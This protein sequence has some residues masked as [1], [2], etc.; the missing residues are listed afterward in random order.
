MAPNKEHEYYLILHKKVCEDEIEMERV[1]DD[2][3][4][5]YAEIVLLVQ[6][7]QKVGLH[8]LD[9]KPEVCA[10]ALGLFMDTEAPIAR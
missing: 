5:A 7:R 3:L 6:R 8:G 1:G 9:R 2:K 4:E 10:T